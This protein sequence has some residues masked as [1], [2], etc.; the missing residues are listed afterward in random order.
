MALNAAFERNPSRDSARFDVGRYVP[1]RHRKRVAPAVFRF[2]V[3]L[4]HKIAR[5]VAIVA[6][7]DRDVSPDNLTIVVD[8]VMYVTLA[9]NLVHALDAKTG[10]VY[11]TYQYALPDRLQRTRETSN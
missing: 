2:G 7:G 6:G 9:D 3:P 1:E 10:L 8:G 5:N 11:W 4:F